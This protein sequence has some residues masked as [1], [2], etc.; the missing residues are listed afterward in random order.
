MGERVVGKQPGTRSLR[1]WTLIR[2]LVLGRM[3]NVVGCGSVSPGYHAACGEQD[4]PEPWMQAGAGRVAEALG[5]AVPVVL[6]MDRIPGAH[7]LDL[8]PAETYHA[9]RTC[10]GLVVRAARSCLVALAELH[11]AGVLHADVKPDNVLLDASCCRAW[12]LDLG[13]ASA[14]PMEV[15]GAG[16]AVA[17]TFATSPLAF[18]DPS[19]LASRELG[20]GWGRGLV[21]LRSDV[22]Q[23]G[24]S[25]SWL[26][27]RVASGAAEAHRVLHAM[28]EPLASVKDV[29]R[30]VMG[31]GEAVGAD[32]CWDWFRTR[33][34]RR[35]HELPGWE[36]DPPGDDAGALLLPGSG[37]PAAALVLPN[38]LWWSSN[39]SGLVRELRSAMD[40]LAGLWSPRLREGLLALLTDM[41]HPLWWCRPTAA[42]ALAGLDVRLGSA[43][44]GPGAA[45]VL[46]PSLRGFGCPL[47]SIRERA[48]A[49]CTGPIR[50]ATPGFA[51]AA[52]AWQVGPEAA[53]M[54]A[55]ARD[56]TV[57]LALALFVRCGS[58]TEAS[59]VRLAALMQRGP[60]GCDLSEEI[61]L[62]EAAKGADGLAMVAALRAA[63]TAEALVLRRGDDLGAAL[64][65]FLGG[66]LV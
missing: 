56:S 47:A 21:S 41:L 35:A 46:P 20:E 10:G 59:A 11:S 4:L 3:L 45:G 1:Q 27:V 42:V 17:P 6:L 26:V 55:A 12:L 19:L 31:A 36:T 29:L 25:L 30:R 66:L 34:T 2:E 61:A 58:L 5:D 15:S 32:T 65:R 64:R 40:G 22:Y 14:V 37:A 8:L 18:Q 23:L 7:A 28:N 54:S 24:I 53:A 49:L 50:C 52:I 48:L 57:V 63:V 44:S 9:M 60:S 51:H 62:V 39:G 38:E 33:Y 13:N 43:A 16:C